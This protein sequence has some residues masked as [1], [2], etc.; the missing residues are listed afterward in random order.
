MSLPHPCDFVFARCDEQQ[1]GQR[2][3]DSSDPRL[4]RHVASCEMAGGG[5]SS[6][7]AGKDQKLSQEFE[8]R[9]LIGREAPVPPLLD[10]VQTNRDRNKGWRKNCGRFS[11]RGESSVTA[12]KMR[13]CRVGCKCWDCS[14]CG[15]RRASMYC[16]R[17]AQTAE[18]LKLNKM[19][20]LTLDPAK[21]QGQDSTRYINEVFAD[22]RVYL[23]RK[24]GRAPSYIRVLEYQK[25]GNAHLHILVACYLPQKW[26]SEA[27]EAVGGG[28]IVDIRMIDMHRV[29]HYLSKYLTK[30]MIELAPARARRVTTSRD[31]R[32]L[33]KQ[34]GGEFAWALL[35]VPLPQ[36]FDRCEGKITKC[37]SDADG[38]LL[39]FETFEE[40]SPMNEPLVR[41]VLHAREVFAC[42]KA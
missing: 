33:E 25:N 5:V 30:Q 13:Y 20:T 41:S 32:L 27:W 6:L 2:F 24:L 18:R 31:I 16:I 11:V 7:P 4:K 17:I 29:S 22:F 37:T 8:D 39:T 36:L 28:R 9:V 19:L 23:R 34:A 38:Y 40:P 3:L 35:R 21:L 1:S 15:P 14:G 10:E 26:V 12:G 42:L